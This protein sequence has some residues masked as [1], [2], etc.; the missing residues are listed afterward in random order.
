MAD[1]DAPLA[2]RMQQD[3]YLMQINQLREEK[4][5]LEHRVDELRKEVERLHADQV[6]WEL[7]N[8]PQCPNVTSLQEVLEQNAK[9]RTLFSSYW[10][11][12][13]SPITPNV[14]RNYIAEMREL[15]VDV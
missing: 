7:G 3:G 10:K 13:H 14:P 5:K 11:A 1:I 9:L 4:Q 12:V 8:C 6:H 15:G 2:W